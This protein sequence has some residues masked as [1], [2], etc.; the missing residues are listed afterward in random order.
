MFSHKKILSRMAL[1]GVV[2]LSACNLNRAGIT[3]VNDVQ[4]QF[5]CPGDN[6]TLSW[7][8]DVGGCLGDGCPSPVIVSISSDPAEVLGSPLTVRLR[9]EQA[10]GPITSNTTFTF[11]ATGGADSRSPRTHDVEVVLPERETFVPLDFASS[12]S[13]SS[14]VWQA[15]DLS[16][17]EFRASGV[18]LVRVCNTHRDQI[19][20]TLSFAS[21]TQRWSL[22]PGMCTEDLPPDL[23]RSVLSASVASLGLVPPGTSCDV[24]ES[25][26][27]PIDLIA[28]L[29]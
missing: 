7:N 11:S 19:T 23:G 10:A 12:C 24:R 29:A 15:V 18:R 9:G 17:P 3:W 27:P 6:V 28:V 8:V 26:P 13:G 2:F 1:C 22:F 16:V 14:A 25:L 21:G 4:P 20:L 5:V